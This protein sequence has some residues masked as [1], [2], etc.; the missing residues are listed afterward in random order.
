MHKQSIFTLWS[1][2]YKNLIVSWDHKFELKCSPKQVS[3]GR[4]WNLSE[5][6]MH[7]FWGILFSVYWMSR[8]PDWEIV[9]QV[10]CGYGDGAKGFHCS[11]E[12]QIRCLSTNPSCTFHS[13]TT[14]MSKRSC[15]LPS[16]NFFH[17]FQGCTYATILFAWV[18]HCIHIHEQQEHMFPS[19]LQFFW[20]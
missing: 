15:A 19:I 2:Y 10:W 5:F 6:M 7:F 16:W 3:G 17:V 20:Q 8:L 13:G 1:K 12:M 18:V 14:P 4:L 9:E 11:A